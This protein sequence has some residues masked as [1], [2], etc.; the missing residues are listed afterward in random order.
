MSEAGDHCTGRGAERQWAEAQGAEV[1]GAEVQG[2]ELPRETGAV[3]W[4]H[5]GILMLFFMDSGR[6]FR[7]DAS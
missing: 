5:R 2:A 3:K 7:Y 6:V 1:Q 4:T